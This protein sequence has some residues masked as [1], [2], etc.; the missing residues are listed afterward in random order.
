MLVGLVVVVGSGVENGLLD[1]AV[2][3][4][5]C[6]V[7]FANEVVIFGLGKKTSVLM[8]VLGLV[9]FDV[10]TVLFGSA[11][12]VGLGV[13]VSVGILFGVVGSGNVVG[14]LFRYAVEV[15]SVMWVGMLNG[16]VSCSEL[17]ALVW[18][19]VVFVLGS[20]WFEAGMLVVVGHKVLFDLWVQ[21]MVETDPEFA[22]AKEL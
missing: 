19:L 2:V 17:K 11:V 14:M 16:F 7:K 18:V 4:V 10:Q 6:L 5:W 3:E 9:V 1:E 12:E 21:V 15:H 20:C 8:K 22:A 13:L